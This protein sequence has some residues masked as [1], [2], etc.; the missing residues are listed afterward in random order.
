[1]TFVS[2]EELLAAERLIAEI[3]DQIDHPAIDRDH[4]E[5]KKTAEAL[6][7]LKSKAAKARA[8]LEMKRY[9]HQHDIN[10]KYY[11]R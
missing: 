1:M 5:H 7:L 11:H 6:Q 2:V 10:E 4:P 3:E 9:F 8:E